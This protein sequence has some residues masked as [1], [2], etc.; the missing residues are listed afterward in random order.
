VN[1]Q[2]RQLGEMAETALGKMLDKGKRKGLPQVPYLR[3]VNVQWGRVDTD[4][5]LTMELADDE[6]ERFGVSPG[7]LLVCEGGEIGRSAIWHGRADYIAYQ[8]ALH[9]IRPSEL[10]DVRFL[11]YLLELYSL[12]GTLVRFATGSTI[13][14][15]PQQQLRRIPVPQ[16][17][18][19]EQRRIVELLEDHFSR[20]EAGGVGIARS[21]KRLGILRE[22]ALAQCVVRAKSAIGGQVVPLGNLGRVTTGTTPLK[23]NRAFYQ[24][25]T[26]PWITSGDL[27]R[28]VIAE[29][30]QFV[31]ERALKETSLKLIPAG[32]ILI[33]MYGE[34]RTRGTAAEL[35]IEATTNQACAALILNE[36]ELRSWVRLMLDANYDALRRM[37]AGGVQ[38]NLNLSL[39][40]AIE[41]PIPSTRVRDEI[42]TQMAEIDFARLRLKQSL[43]VAS[44]RCASI[45]RALLSAAFSG[46]LTKSTLHP[47]ELGV[48]A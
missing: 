25:G 16:A 31:T 22:A 41:V 37:A 39:V 27:H 13:A 19:D 18:I 30:S 15:L 3:N 46:R 6:R 36:P 43:A 11:R 7:D 42:S 47:S 28:G 21:L 32:A 23:S 38:P 5:L 20:L 34:G 26:V 14:H 40:R 2:V 10:L 4:D 24:N 12:D 8:K 9:R 33:A 35:A 17:P 48:G 44:A 1:W 29:A 45:R